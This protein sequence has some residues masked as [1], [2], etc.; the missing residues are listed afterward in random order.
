MK[1]SEAIRLGSMLKPQGFGSVHW[2]GRTCA[3]GAAMDAVGGLGAGECFSG[4]YAWIRRW[5][6]LSSLLGKPCH[7]CGEPMGVEGIV[8][9]H[10]NDVHQWTREQIATFVEGIEQQ[11]DA[12]SP[13]ELIAVAEPCPSR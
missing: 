5:P 9:T 7:V 10:L 3:M 11:Q 1:L 13:T 2:D 6:V 4:W 8:I 12:T